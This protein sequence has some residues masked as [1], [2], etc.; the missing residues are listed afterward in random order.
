MKRFIYFWLLITV[1]FL[2]C[3]AQSNVPSDNLLKKADALFD[4]KD[5]AEAVKFYKE[6]GSQGNLDALNKLGFCYMYGTGIPKNSIL[7]T[8]CFKRAAEKGYAKAQFNLANCYYM[9]QGIG[10]NH[11]KSAEWM[12]KAA[13]QNYEPAMQ[14]IATYYK[15]GIGVMIDNVLADVW[16]K[17]WMDKSTQEL[18][19]EQA[20]KSRQMETP[21]PQV[22]KSVQPQASQPTVTAATPIT[23]SPTTSSAITPPVAVAPPT[24]AQTEKVEAK[25]DG[26][27]ELGA[28]IQVLLSSKAPAAS[29]PAVVTPAPAVQAPQ[30]A[31]PP[32]KS[33]SSDPFSAPTPTPAVSTTTVAPTPVQQAANPA[34]DPFGS[35]APTA[36]ASGP[37]PSPSPSPANPELQKANESTSAIPTTVPSIKILYPDN[38]TLFHDEAMNIK[39][40]ILNGDETNTKVTVLIDGIRQPVNR[41]VKAANSLEVDLPKKDC[42]VMLMV[43]NQFGYGAPANVQLSWDKSYDD[44][45]LPNLYVLSIG[46]GKYVDD[47]LP[48]LKYSTKDA[49][50]IANALMNKKGKPYGDVQVKLICDSAATRAGIFDGLTWLKEHATP[51]DVSIFFYAGHGYRD[52]KDRFFFMPIDGKSDKT[53]TCFSATDFRTIVEDIRGK[54]VIFTDACYSAAL[55]EGNRSAATDHFIEQLRRS[56]DGVFLIASSSADTKSK[57]D[58]AWSNG[59]FTKALI[60]AMNGAAKHEKSEGLSLMDLQLYLDKRVGELTDHKQVPVAINPN[61]IENFSIFLYDSK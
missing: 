23:P 59:A 43:Q 41:A 31:V 35:V 58:D 33:A 11:K 38:Q 34:A 32:S 1:G 16:N 47:K 39:Y 26:N 21:S 51:N 25:T 4:A 54:F 9:G 28:A 3:F 45:V 14:N 24:V 36:P 7:A 18:R 17:K 2:G 29:V 6:A 5:Y 19:E 22:P 8:N 20:L 60:E 55:M 42:S 56:R 52:E 44:A 53:Y 15:Q 46:I 50:D 13:E 61:G 48:P 37:L 57:E 10:I 49:S 40:Q 30:V 12:L 27:S